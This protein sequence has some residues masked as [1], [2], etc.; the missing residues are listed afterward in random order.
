MIELSTS[1]KH[2]GLI[3]P[4]KEAHLDINPEMLYACVL[5]LQKHACIHSHTK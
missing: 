3:Q 4:L 5:H 1:E 2:I